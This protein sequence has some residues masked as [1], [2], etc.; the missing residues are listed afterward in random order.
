MSN[1]T[2]REL[3]EATKSHC[4]ET[5]SLHRRD[6]VHSKIKLLQVRDYIILTPY[7]VEPG[8][9]LIS[10]VRLNVDDWKPDMR[11]NAAFVA[12]GDNAGIVINKPGSIMDFN[13]NQAGQKERQQPPNAKMSFK[14]F[15]INS[16]TSKLT[17]EHR[18]LRFWLDQQTFVQTS[19]GND[20]HHRD[21]Q[22]ND[23]LK[24]I[25]AFANLKQESSHLAQSYFCQLIGSKPDDD[26]PKNYVAFLMK[27]MRLLKTSQFSRVVKMEVELRQLDHEDHTK[28]PS[29]ACKYI[30]CFTCFSPII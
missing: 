10:I 8:H 5:V 17:L 22:E 25:K 12:E 7:P 20:Q 2:G 6:E 23:D 29:R 9:T 1:S 21:N 19:R 11:S 26:F 4:K 16:E 18:T 30:Q 24:S 28:P 15:L 14:V 27:L 13:R 3:D